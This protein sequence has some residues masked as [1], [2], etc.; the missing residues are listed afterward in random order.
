MSQPTSNKLIL[1]EKIN[2][3]FSH[4]EIEIIK[5]KLNSS[6]EKNDINFINEIFSFKD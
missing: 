4:E 3:V 2:K 1:S 5:S 6:L